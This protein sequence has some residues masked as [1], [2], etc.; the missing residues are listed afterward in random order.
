MAVE[1]I[2]RRIHL[3]R[4][5]KVMMDSDLAALYQVE[6]RVLNQAVR[7][8]LDRFPEDFMFRLNTT[9]AERLRSQFVIL[10]PTRG[11]HSKYLPYAF[12]EHGVAMLS[13]VLTSKRAVQMNIQI[14]RAFV[15]LRELIAVHSDI[16]ERLERLEDGQKEHGDALTAVIEELTR[17][18]SKPEPSKR[19]IGF[20]AQSNLPAIGAKATSAGD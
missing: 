12:T 13:S 7:R 11:A 14:V 20:Q 2:E 4:G 1:A 10:N 5:Q 18:T 16:A 3:I 9:E 8:N 6:T 15:N 19:R 17:M